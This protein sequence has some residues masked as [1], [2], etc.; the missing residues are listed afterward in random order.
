MSDPVC[1]VSGPGIIPEIGP[2]SMWYRRSTCPFLR[3][4]GLHLEHDP[5]VP[6]HN[7]AWSRTRSLTCACSVLRSGFKRIFSAR[8]VSFHHLILREGKSKYRLALDSH[9]LI[10]PMHRSQLFPRITS[11]DIY[12]CG[13]EPVGWHPSGLRLESVN[14][15]LS[16]ARL[17]SGAPAS[18]MKSESYDI[19]RSSFSGLPPGGHEVGCR[20]PGRVGSNPTELGLQVEVVGWILI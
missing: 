20:F 4:R 15:S 10:Q 9:L 1:Q 11:G 2:F 7:C 18:R 16:T 8:G 5:C 14:S 13:A 17:V 12:C 3:R 19:W 6:C